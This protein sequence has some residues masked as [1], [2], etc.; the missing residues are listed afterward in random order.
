MKTQSYTNFWQ[1]I[2]QVAAVKGF[3]LR[4]MFELTYN[5]NFHC[6]HCYI[7]FSYQEQYK[8]KELKTKEVFS[9]LEQLKDMGCFYLGFTGGEPFYRKDILKILWYAKKCGFEIIIYTN[10]S[11]IN[12]K[13]AAELVK[14]RPNKVDITIPAMNE[15]VFARI[16]GV[17]QAKNSV[18]KAIKLLSK[19]GIK[20]GFKSCLLNDNESEMQDIIKFSRNLKVFHRLDDKLSAC[21]DGSKE[22]YKYRSSST[23]SLLNKLKFKKEYSAGCNFKEMPLQSS[24]NANLFPCGA[25]LTQA[26]ITPAG[27]LKLCLM[28][29]YPKYNILDMSLKKAWQKLRALAD[30]VKPDR[31]YKCNRCKLNAYCDWCPAYAWLENKNFTGC[32]FESKLWAGAGKYAFG[33]N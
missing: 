3:P 22:P 11:L 4:V 1:R 29:G 13:T 9:V 7:P 12:E 33:K 25:G 17:S 26:A 32:S 2:H 21:L 27:E 15:E 19:S 28:I 24:A 10:G 16:T 5:C 23:V 30:S 6:R 20:L 8:K 14:L 31:N 18:F